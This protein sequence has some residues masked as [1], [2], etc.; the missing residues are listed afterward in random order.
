[1]SIEKNKE[2]AKNFY[3][4]AYLGNPR[5][6][7]E[8]YVGDNYFQHNPAVEDGKQGFID[9]FEEMHAYCPD[10]Q[11][12]FLRIVGEED[13]VSLHTHQTWGAPDNKEYVTMD[14]FRFEAG[15]IVEHW[16]AIQEVVPT[17]SGRSMY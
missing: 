11:I 12:E 16:D 13:L 17:K 15:K 4:T 3:E 2:T 10:K 14:F 7:I 8:K 5:L 6:A 9:Y 1:M